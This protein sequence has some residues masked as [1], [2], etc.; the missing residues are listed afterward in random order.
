M[1]LEERRTI[2]SI[3]GSGQREQLHPTAVRHGSQTPASGSPYHQL[4][5][6]AIN[7][8]QRRREGRKIYSADKQTRAAADVRSEN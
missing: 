4:I 7:K 1:G 6:H 8:P 3:D 2:I 5:V